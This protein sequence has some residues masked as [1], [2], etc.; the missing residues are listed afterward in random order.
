MIATCR[1]GRSWT[2][3]RAEHC[4]ACHETF[5][6]TPSG[7]RHRV[8]DHGEGSRRCLTRGEMQISGMGTDERGA[9]FI[10]ALREANVAKFRRDVALTGLP[11]T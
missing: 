7:D 10:V 8:G 4:P 11:G 3:S 1:C 6:G 9:W 5:T 2:G